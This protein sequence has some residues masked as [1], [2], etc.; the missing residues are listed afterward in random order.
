[1]TQQLLDCIYQLCHIV[2][3]C[4]F[5]HLFQFETTE[6]WDTSKTQSLWRTVDSTNVSWMV[7][8]K[9]ESSSDDSGLI[10]KPYWE[11]APNSIIVWFEAPIH[12][13]QTQHYMTAYAFLDQRIRP[14]WS[15]WNSEH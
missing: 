15:R 12:G 2:L 11:F 1:L 7:P 9:N 14:S 13:S 4:N 6:S 3:C 5:I 8:A 10:Q